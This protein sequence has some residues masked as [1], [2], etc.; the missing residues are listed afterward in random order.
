MLRQ[1]VSK[2]NKESVK[3]KELSDIMRDVENIYV[4]KSQVIIIMFR[5]VENI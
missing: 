4:E 3:Q 2:V 5:D 1:T